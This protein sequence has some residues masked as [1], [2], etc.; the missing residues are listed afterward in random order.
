MHKH[1]VNLG[2]VDFNLL[3][4]E[5]LLEVSPGKIDNS[6][7]G[8]CKIEVYGGEGPIPHFHI[9]GLTK[10]FECCPCIFQPL[11]FN[12]GTK[13]DTLTKNQLKILDSWLREPCTKFGG[14]LTNW[15]VIVQL[16]ESC[17]NPLKNFKLE[18][19]QPDYTKMKN[20]RN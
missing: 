17:G 3:S 18:S 11:Y 10:K 19:T 6:I 12:H 5:F 1:I 13:T 15:E 20:M 14:V 9:I 2:Y 7:I 16:W 4:D 8:K